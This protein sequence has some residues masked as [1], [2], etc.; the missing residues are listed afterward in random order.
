MARREQEHQKR[1]P[2]PPD[3]KR[4]SYAQLLPSLELDGNLFF[5]I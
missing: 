4:E 2:V 1:S 5:S 3:D